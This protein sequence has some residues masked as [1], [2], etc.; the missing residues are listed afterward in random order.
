MLRAKIIRTTT[1]FLMC[2]QNTIEL[3][4][5]DYKQTFNINSVEVQIE[6]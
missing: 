1:R 4:P 2:L 5:A 3:Y 6:R